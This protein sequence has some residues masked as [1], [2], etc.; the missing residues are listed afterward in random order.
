MRHHTR[1]HP[2]FL[3]QIGWKE[4]A[5]S[6]IG[7]SYGIRLSC[8]GLQEAS[9]QNTGSRTIDKQQILR[10]QHGGSVQPTPSRLGIAK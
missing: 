10:V 5:G 1:L 4:M 8:R 6:Y 3:T 9:V 2:I 7:V